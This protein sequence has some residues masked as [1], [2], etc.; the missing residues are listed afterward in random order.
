MN[1]TILSQL[2]LFFITMELFVL[3]LAYEITK[4]KYESIIKYPLFVVGFQV[5]LVAIYFFDNSGNKE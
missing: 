3:A 2:L 5:I 1:K 4:Y